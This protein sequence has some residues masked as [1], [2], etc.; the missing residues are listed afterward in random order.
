[1]A[2]GGAY[3]LDLTEVNKFHE[4]ELAIPSTGKDIP[5]M[6]NEAAIDTTSS[7]DNEKRNSIAL[8]GTTFDDSEI[9]DE[10]LHT[11][12]RVAGKIPWTTYTIAFV[13]FCERFSYYGTTTV[14]V[15]FIQRPMPPGSNTGAGFEGQSGALDMGQRAST[16]LTTFNQFW[17]YLMPLV[18]AYV[19]DQYLGRYKTIQASIGIALLGHF[20]LIISAIPP[21]ITHPVGA[22]VCFAIGLVIMGV[23]TGGFK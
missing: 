10:D 23:G 2:S 8:H 14:F 4:P 9:S 19:A 22:I 17:A 13:E 6:E 3:L 12:R 20:L 15:N 7:S 1:M 11:L 21:V 18:G 16:G 5:S